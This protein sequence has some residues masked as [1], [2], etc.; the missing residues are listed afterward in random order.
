MDHAVGRL[1]RYLE[2]EGLKEQTMVFF[3]SDNGSQVPGSNKP[4]RG[5]K[6]FNLEGG[7]RVPFLVRWIGTVP[8]GRVSEVA[9]SFTDVLPTLASLTGS[10]LPPDRVLDGEDLSRVLTGKQPDYQRERPVF[11]FRYFHDPVCMLREGDRVLLG[12]QG[13]PLDDREDYDQRAL[14]NLRPDSGTARWSMWNFQPRHM[15]YI[16]GAV[17]VNFQLFDIRSDIGQRKD[18]SGA[19]PEETERMKQKMLRLREEMIREG[20]NWYEETE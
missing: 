7:I 15:E 18:L 16:P 2:E 12:Y 9:G 8:A 10:E 1:L 14:A 17:P 5:E 3:T 6:A 4:L 13:E 19:Y 11:F 20:G